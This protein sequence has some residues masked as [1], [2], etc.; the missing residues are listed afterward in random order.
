MAGRTDAPVDSTRLG[1]AVAMEA[2]RDDAT[3][4]STASQLDRVKVD[5]VLDDEDGFF[6][7]IA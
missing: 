7:V 3:A 6:G 4:S 5:I 1:G 2:E